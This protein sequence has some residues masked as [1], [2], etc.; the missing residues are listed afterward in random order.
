MN[1]TR[2]LGKSL[3]PGGAYYVPI[4]VG[5]IVFFNYFY[6]FLQLDPKARCAWEG[7][8]APRMCKKR[9]EKKRRAPETFWRGLTAPQRG[10][11][12]RPRCAARAYACAGAAR[13]GATTA[14]NPPFSHW[15]ATR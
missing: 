8:G 7:S 6:T 5:L 13:G 10:R 11:T 12:A 1:G 14:S 4:N 2:T 9:N 3:F 15:S